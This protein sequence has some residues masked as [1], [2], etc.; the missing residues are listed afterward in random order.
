MVAGRC[1]V[2]VLWFE[3]WKLFCTEMPRKCWRGKVLRVVL[4][5]Y[6]TVAPLAAQNCHLENV[7]GLT[8]V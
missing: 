2:R 6:I 5:L 3:L 4:M 7:S 8:S 1:A